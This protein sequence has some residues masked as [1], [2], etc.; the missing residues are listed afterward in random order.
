MKKILVITMVLAV[1]AAMVVPLAVGATG[2]DKTTTISG[3]VQSIAVLVA[4]SPVD[5]ITLSQGPNSKSEL[6]I[7]DGAGSVADNNPSGYVVSVK[8][9]QSGKMQSLTGNKT[10]TLSN[11]LLVA[12]GTITTAQDV[13]GGVTCESSSIPTD[14]VAIPLSVS[15]TIVATDA[16]GAYSIVLT[17]T[18]TENPNN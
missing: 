16:N 4:P 2:I 18:M 5:F 8:S 14:A 1:V 12:T 3:N 11:A 17:Y 9:N 6:T 15:Q 7:S 13:S 10:S